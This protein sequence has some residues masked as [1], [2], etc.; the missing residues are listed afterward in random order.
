MVGSLAS[1]ASLL[2]SAVRAFRRQRG[3]PDRAKLDWVQPIIES[4]GLIS[5]FWAMFWPR[6]QNQENE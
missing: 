6:G 3:S 2:V 4:A 1:S 5:S